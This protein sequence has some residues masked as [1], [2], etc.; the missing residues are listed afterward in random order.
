[1]P[2]RFSIVKIYFCTQNY[3][4]VQELLFSVGNSHYPAA[5]V[6]AVDILN[7]HPKEEF[8]A[9]QMP[10]GFGTQK[11]VISMT[12]AKQVEEGLIRLSAP[13]PNITAKFSA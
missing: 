13:G 9:K 2:N 11:E 10:E 7:S 1:M 5:L 6:Q 4:A 8:A 12:L 3:A